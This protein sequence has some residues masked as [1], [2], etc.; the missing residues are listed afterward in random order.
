MAAYAGIAASEDEESC[1]IAS[2][3]TKNMALMLITKNIRL[4]FLAYG[5]LDSLFPISMSPTANL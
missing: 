5:S 2:S 4:Q 1:F 3:V